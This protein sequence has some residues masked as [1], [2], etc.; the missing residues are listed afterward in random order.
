MTTSLTDVLNT[1]GAKERMHKLLSPKSVWRLRC[2]N[3]AT[4]RVVDK[5][6]AYRSFVSGFPS[7]SEKVVRALGYTGTTPVKQGPVDQNEYTGTFVWTCTDGSMLVPVM[8]HHLPLSGDAKRALELVNED[9]EQVS[10][11]RMTTA[12]R[13]R[14]ETFEDIQRARQRRQKKHRIEIPRLP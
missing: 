12:R 14:L 2:L 3:R 1:V 9:M 10:P 8:Q 4:K 13:M 7:K 5:D 6:Y 11:T